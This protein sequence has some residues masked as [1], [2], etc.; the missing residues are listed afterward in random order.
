MFGEWLGV[1][2]PGHLAATLL[3]RQQV[4]CWVCGFILLDALACCTFPLTSCGSPPPCRASL[5]PPISQRHRPEE[6]PGPAA[7]CGVPEVAAGAA[8]HHP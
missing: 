4:C 8:L 1:L 5:S 2:H 3:L 7:V 6:A